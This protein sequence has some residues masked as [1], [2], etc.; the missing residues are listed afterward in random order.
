MSEKFGN[1]DNYLS[2]AFSGKRDLSASYKFYDGDYG[3]YLPQDKGASILDV[4]CGNGEFITYLRSKG[5]T[6]VAGIDASGEMVDFC[7]ANGITG[8]SRV[9]DTTG[10]LTGNAGKFDLVAMNDVIEHLPKGDTIGILKSIRSS[11]TQGGVF[12][13]RTGNFSTLGGIYLRYKD[14]THEIGYTEASLEQAL[15]SA[16]FSDITV[17][18]NKNY[19]NFKNPMSILRA[20]ALKSWFFILKALYT[21]ELGCDRPR[22]YSKLLVA[23]CKR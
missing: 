15:R 1:F 23:V 3:S 19:V 4:G 2:T 12:L 21:I 22:V 14:F 17:L 10:Y 18:G 11:L 6:N 7:K 5:F 8:V 20:V 16:G 13:L 9:T